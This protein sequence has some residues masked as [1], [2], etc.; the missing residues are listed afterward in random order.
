MV[1]PVGP[2]ADTQVVVFRMVPAEVRPVA[3]LDHFVDW[4]RSSTR[5]VRTVAAEDRL[6]DITQVTQADRLVVT[7]A[8]QHQFEPFLMVP[9]LLFN[10]MLRYIPRLT[11]PAC[12]ALRCSRSHLDRPRLTSPL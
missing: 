2:L 6:V 4:Y 3:E 8:T 5:V 11:V 7:A 1:H 10:R 12:T 9:V